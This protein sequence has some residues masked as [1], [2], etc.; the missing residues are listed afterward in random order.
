M[1]GM[2]VF[3]PVTD[4]MLEQGLCPDEL[5]AYQPGNLLKS[6]LNE[7]KPASQSSRRVKRSPGATPNSDD[8]P[9]LSSSTYMAG[10]LLG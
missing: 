9:A 5:V 1:W 3:V 7:A 2:K 10:A 6:Q 4:E 8:V